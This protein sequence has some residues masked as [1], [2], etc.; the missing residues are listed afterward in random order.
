VPGG[1]G[2][3]D[4]QEDEDYFEDDNEN[5]DES[6]HEWLPDDEIDVAVE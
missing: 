4:V 6:A 3:T 2:A 5:Y 1:W